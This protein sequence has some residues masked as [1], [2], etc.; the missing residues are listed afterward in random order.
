MSRAE[1]RILDGSVWNDFCD[2]LKSLG[3]L[4]CRP[5]SPGDVLNR[6]LGYR[7]LTRLL[8]GGWRTRVLMSCIGRFLVLAL[9]GGL[10]AAIGFLKRLRL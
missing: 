1:E 5:E 7:Y 9:C 3:D 4:V 6:A 8:R 10:G 2:Q